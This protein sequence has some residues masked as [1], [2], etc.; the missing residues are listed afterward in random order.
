M[1]LEF[2][3]IPKLALCL[4]SYGIGRFY[5][6]GVYYIIPPFDN[7]TNQIQKTST[8]MVIDSRG[9]QINVQSMYVDGTPL[10]ILG[11]VAT[12]LSTVVPYTVLQTDI[13][14][15]LAQSFTLKA[16]V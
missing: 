16:E 2:D 3:V 4:P 5:V 15:A 12:R 13:Y 6:A 8:P 14:N 1:T 7:S 10:T 11:E 9:Y